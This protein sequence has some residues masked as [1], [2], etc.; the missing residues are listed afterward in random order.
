[1]VQ[2]LHITTGLYVSILFNLTQSQQPL[3]SLY[4]SSS[5]I[6]WKAFQYNF[7]K[8]SSTSIFRE[9]SSWM[10]TRIFSMVWSVQIWPDQCWSSVAISDL[11]KRD[12]H[13][14]KCFLFKSYF[15]SHSCIIHKTWPRHPKY[16]I[17]VQRESGQWEFSTK[18]SSIGKKSELCLHPKY[19]NNDTA[20][21]AR[22]I[23]SHYNNYKSELGTDVRGDGF[24]NHST[25]IWP[26]QDIKRTRKHRECTKVCYR[27]AYRDH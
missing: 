5:K 21:E 14:Y 23:F 13:F 18:A 1:M 12:Y 20:A 25:T 27:A 6:F 15:Y 3:F 10:K 19:R 11:F 8:S 17:E 26:T 7:Y 24:Y 4:K 2:F 16:E 9:P 22:W